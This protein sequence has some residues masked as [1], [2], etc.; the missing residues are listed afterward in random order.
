M[1]IKFIAQNCS[2]ISLGRK[3][4]Y[5]TYFF[6]NMKYYCLIFKNFV[7]CIQYYAS[8]IKIGRIIYKMKIDFETGY[9]KPECCLSCLLPPLYHFIDWR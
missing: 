4:K 1:I 6:F 2:E 3:R 8:V 9:G 7:N 5:I